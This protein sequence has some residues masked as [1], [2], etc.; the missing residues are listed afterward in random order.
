MR[1][2][3]LL[4]LFAASI[5]T[6][7]A[8]TSETVTISGSSTNKFVTEISVDGDNATVTYNDGTKATADMDDV[9][10]ELSYQATIGSNDEEN[11]QMLQNFGGRTIDVNIDR[12]FQAGEWTT[13]CLPISMTA[14]QIATAF[15]SGTKVAAFDNVKNGNVNFKSQT[16][17]EAGVPYVIL[18]AQNVSEFTVEDT[19]L[20]NITAG[21]EYTGDDWTFV[22]TISSESPSGNIKTVGS[23]S[24]LKTITNVEPLSAY[25]K[26]A[27]DAQA[28][29]FSIDGAT[30]GIMSIESG[31]AKVI[32]RG[33]Y[34]LRGQYMG[35][36]V[37][38][39]PHG[40]Y[41]IN[42]KKVVK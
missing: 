25:L 2:T 22:G 39:L 6:A 11:T 42:G 5:I 18:P 23:D 36:S 10:L 9:A 26:G 12:D 30:T 4:A 20:H 32:N 19:Q 15:G 40:V 31:A 28:E 1:K 41:I 37:D 8:Q 34:N 24:K 7:Q 35:T 16:S 17:I 21:A 29:T 3:L 38:A 14:E 13:I 27:A 33:I